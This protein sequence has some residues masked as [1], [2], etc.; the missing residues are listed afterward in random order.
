MVART[1]TTVDWRKYLIEDDNPRIQKFL[2]SRGHD[3]FNQVCSTINEAVLQNRET[4]A[5]VVHPNAAGAILI[6]KKDFEIVYEIALNWFLK[7]E[8]YEECALIQKYKF[9]IKKR[10]SKK[11][12]DSISKHKH[13]I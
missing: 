2:D 11:K 6:E 4:V 13:L 3:V 8:L 1:Y 5:M 7:K 9:E 12:V 10:T